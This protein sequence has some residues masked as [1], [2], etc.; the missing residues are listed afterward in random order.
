MPLCRSAGGDRKNQVG[1]ITTNKIFRT[2]LYL[3][4]LPKCQLWEWLPSSYM[5]TQRDI[6]LNQRNAETQVRLNMQTGSYFKSYKQIYL[7]KVRIG[8]R[9]K[10]EQLNEA[11][12]TSANEAHLKKLKQAK[13]NKNERRWGWVKISTWWN[14]DRKYW[15]GI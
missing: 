6:K 7:L 3:Y 4:N 13:K 9:L 5:Q 8:E 2:Q 10:M 15:A 12:V 14:R 11:M 1:Y